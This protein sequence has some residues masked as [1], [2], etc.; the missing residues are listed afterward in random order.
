MNHLLNYLL[1]CKK[2]HVAAAQLKH[3]VHTSVRFLLSPV[4]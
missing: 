2:I 3:V 1:L 4:N